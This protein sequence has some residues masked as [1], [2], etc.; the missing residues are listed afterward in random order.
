MGHAKKKSIMQRVNQSRS[1]RAMKKL[2]SLGNKGGDEVL[3]LRGGIVDFA[4]VVL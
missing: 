3:V 1:C 2:G 4:R